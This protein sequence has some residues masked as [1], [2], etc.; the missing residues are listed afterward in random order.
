VRKITVS[1]TEQNVEWLQQASDRRGLAVSD[2]IR[3]MI[4][5]ASEPN[6]VVRCEGRGVGLVKTDNDARHRDVSYVLDFR[7]EVPNP[8]GEDEYDNVFVLP[9]KATVAEA[10]QGL[11]LLRKELIDA[12]RRVNGWETLL[13]LA[14]HQGLGPDAR[15]EV[16]TKA[17][18]EAV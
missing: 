14:R 12:A 10:T 7:L 11:E 5:D 6:P 3:R 16:L 18:E 4:D 2:L 13:E 17:A 1:L 8:D 15:I 9:L